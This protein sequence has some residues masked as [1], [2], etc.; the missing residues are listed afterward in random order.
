MEALLIIG[1]LAAGAHY[2]NKEDDPVQHVYSSQTTEQISK[3]RADVQREAIM[4]S[5]DWSKPGN[6]VVGDSPQ[7]GVQWVFVTGD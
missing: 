1:A 5:I 2:M 7:T 4:A 6:S 3:F